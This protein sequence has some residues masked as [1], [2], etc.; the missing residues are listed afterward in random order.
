M[1]LSATGKRIDLASA[2]SAPQET[3]VTPIPWLEQVLL[4]LAFAVFLSIG[5]E[6]PNPELG[7]SNLSN[8]LGMG[9]ALAIT[10]P[11]VLFYWRQTFPMVLR[12]PL[13]VAFIILAFASVLWSVYPN[14]TFKRSGSLLAPVLVG[15]VA[16]HRYQP[17]EVI[18]FTGRFCLLLTAVSLVVVIAFPAVGIMHDRYNTEIDGAWRGFT[19]HKSVFGTILV[20]GFEIYVWRTLFES[21]RRWRHAGIAVAML[22]ICYLARSS[23]GFIA[24]GF[25]MPLLAI[26]AVRRSQA[27]LRWLPELAFW[28]LLILAAVFLP[29]LLGTLLQM[30]GKDLSLTG[31]IP[32]WQSLIPFIADRPLG[33]YGYGAFWIS[34]SPQ[35]ILVTQM[36]PWRPPDAHNAYLGVA[37]ELGLTGA[38]IATTFLLSVLIRAYRLSRST[39]LA[40]VSYIF[41]FSFIYVVTSMVETPLLANGSFFTFML[42]FCHFSLVQHGL[43][44]AEQNVPAR[45]VRE[46]PG[47]ALTAAADPGQGLRFRRMSGQRAAPGAKSEPPR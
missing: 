15:L 27:R 19:P 22:V 2:T 24:M 45:K 18:R 39:G 4:F 20:L 14:L 10:V 37:L 8:T 6:D 7:Q 41:V 47:V 40:W 30:L 36:N 33:G 5:P 46:A 28:G 43:K 1:A 44:Q 16:A 34:K 38:A 26:I 21:K 32:L 42:A 35:L 23:T 29:F 3:A 9:A 25:S 12:S 11:L 13:L 31:R 17:R